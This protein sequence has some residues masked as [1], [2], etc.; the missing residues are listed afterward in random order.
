MPLWIHWWNAIWLLR[1]GCTH[2]RTF[3]WFST[4]VVVDGVKARLFA[5]ALK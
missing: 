3:L 4:C 1:P 2:L 5:A